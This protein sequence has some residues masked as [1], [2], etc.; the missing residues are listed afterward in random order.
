LDA[1]RIVLQ[2]ID[3]TGSY[4]NDLTVVAEIPQEPDS[5][6]LPYA[7]L[8]RGEERYNDAGGALTQ[9]NLDFIIEAWAK[10]SPP[11]ENSADAADKMLQDIDRAVATDR[12]LGSTVIDVKLT[13]NQEFTSTA[14]DSFC[15]VLVEGTLTYRHIHGSP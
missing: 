8:L 2:G 4:N 3:G 10:F 14:G 11:G 1:L 5:G 7:V 13:K 12:S 6:L 15:V 9:R